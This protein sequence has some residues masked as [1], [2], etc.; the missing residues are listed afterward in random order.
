[1]K[2]DQGMWD[3]GFISLEKLYI[4]RHV[5][6]KGITKKKG[7]KRDTAKKETA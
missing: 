7:R 6:R 1:M 2:S 3:L 4:K 5:E